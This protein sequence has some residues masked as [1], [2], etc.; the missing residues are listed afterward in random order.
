[1]ANVGGPRRHPNPLAISSPA[2]TYG[3]GPFLRPLFF[4]GGPALRAR[5]SGGEY[6]DVRAR[7]VVGLSLARVPAICPVTLHFRARAR[8][9]QPTAT[10]P[11]TTSASTTR[12]TSRPVMHA[13][14]PSPHHHSAAD[15]I[16]VSV[17]AACKQLLVSWASGWRVATGAVREAA[18]ALRQAETRRRWANLFRFRSSYHG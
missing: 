12:S 10:V 4:T 9:L 7:P 17:H 6:Q 14:V 11:T 15:S 2:G 13:T 16:A 18:A 5:I 8:P 1:V 3:T